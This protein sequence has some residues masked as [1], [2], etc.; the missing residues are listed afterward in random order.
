[1]TLWPLWSGIHFCLSSSV[2]HVLLH[3]LL[4]VLVRALLWSWLVPMQLCQVSRGCLHLFHHF[5]PRWLEHGPPRCIIR[6]TGDGF[7]C[8]S[9][10]ARVGN[11][12]FQVSLN[13][14]F[15][16]GSGHC[17]FLPNWLLKLVEV[18]CG[19]C[20]HIV[21]QFQGG[22]AGAANISWRQVVGVKKH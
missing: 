14:R 7:S 1:M 20:G 15:V 22:Q 17:L 8:Y 10:S 18:F 3:Q 21:S 19:L 5:R 4:P 11:S 6:F 9:A 13:K 16:V 2:C 12:V